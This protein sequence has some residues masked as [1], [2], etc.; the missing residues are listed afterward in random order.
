M[1]CTDGAYLEDGLA[2]V[3][4]QGD[5]PESSFNYDRFD[6][7]T[8]PKTEHLTEANQYRIK[9][10]ATVFALDEEPK[11]K[12]GKACKILAAQI[13]LVVGVGVTKSFFELLPGTNTWNP[14]P[15]EHITGHH[16]MVLIGYNSIEKYFELFNSFGPSWGQDGFVRVPFDDFERLCRYAYI[17]MPGLG[18]SDTLSVNSSAL[19]LANPIKTETLLAGEFVFRQPAGILTNEAG[20]ELVYF[21]EVSTHLDASRQGFYVTQSE[22]FPVGDGFQLVAREIPKGRYVY[23][24]SQNPAGEINQHFPRGEQS[25]RIS[26]GFVLDENAEIV[27]PNEE[28]VLQLPMPGEDHLCILYCHSPITDFEERLKM[29]G[30]QQAAFPDK[31]NAVFGDLLI[32]PKDAQFSTEKMSFTAIADPGS[33]R[34][35]TALT[36]RVLAK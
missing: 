2:L 33:G 26:A 16:A 28:S 7:S 24:F 3:K 5:C 1:D 12:I 22:D 36:L 32:D 20:E 23:V 31:I 27:I 6:C 25:T 34:I 13:P 9:D 29:L 18:K 14:D 30:E 4:A 19:A 35:A 21:E 10:F 17:M 15:K 11:L 8:L